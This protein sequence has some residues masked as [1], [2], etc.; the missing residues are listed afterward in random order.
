MCDNWSHADKLISRS[1]FLDSLAVCVQ[2]DRPVR[3]PGDRGE[4]CL[5]PLLHPG[6]H[7]IHHVSGV[8]H[9][10]QARALLASPEG[11]CSL[12]VC[13]CVFFDRVMY[14]K[15]KLIEAVEKTN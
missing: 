1:L 2:P 5:T 9:S 15:T 14:F 11:M 8:L 7:E 4:S 10:L 13:V 12:V 3:T 6:G